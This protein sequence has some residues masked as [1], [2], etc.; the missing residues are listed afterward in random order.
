[1]TAITV[2]A[3]PLAYQVLRTASAQA[4]TGQTDWVSV[5]AW[6]QSVTLYFNITASGGTTPG[7]VTFAIKS[8]DPV[9][10]DDGTAV[11]YVTSASITTL[12]TYHELQ[13]GPTLVTANNDS[14]TANG[15]KVQNSPLPALLGATVTLDRTN[16]DETYTYTLAIQFHK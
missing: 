9:L 11:T 6:A 3:D 14:S 12:T 8:A 16:A 7:P 5:P 13:L 4:N 2:V 10:R 1:M 15:F